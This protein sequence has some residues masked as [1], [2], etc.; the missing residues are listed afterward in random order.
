ME[1]DKKPR[2][3]TADKRYRKFSSGKLRRGKSNVFLRNI[4]AN[5]QQFQSSNT[6]RNS[7]VPQS[8]TKG[9]R[10]KGFKSGGYKAEFLNTSHDFRSNVASSFGYGK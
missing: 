1:L 7:I 9:E 3:R 4:P 5:V 10:F 2:S 6:L 8:F